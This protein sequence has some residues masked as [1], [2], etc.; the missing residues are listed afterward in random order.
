MKTIHLLKI[1]W[2]KES[3]K[4]VSG[5][6]RMTF[7]DKSAMD[8]WLAG[9][10]KEHPLLEESDI[11]TWSHELA[12]NQ[13]FYR[14]Y[15]ADSDILTDSDAILTPARDKTEARKIGARYIRAW[16]LSSQ[17]VRKVEQIV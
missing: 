17:S 8:A 11:E 10:R 5:T 1:K 2:H 4:W 9:Y 12:D 14:V 13:H 6:D 7:T 16:N 15:I 3:D